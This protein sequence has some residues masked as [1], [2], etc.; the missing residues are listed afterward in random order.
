MTTTI[1]RPTGMGN[2][3]SLLSS[4]S[5][6]S[7]WANID[8]S[9]ANDSDEAHWSSGS[10]TYDEYTFGNPTRIGSETIEKIVITARIKASVVSAAPYQDFNLYIYDGTGTKKYLGAQQAGTVYVNQEWELTTNWDDDA[11]TWDDLDG[12]YVGVGLSHN[13]AGSTYISQLFVTVTYGGE[14]AY[15]DT[16]G[17]GINT[18]VGLG[19]DES[20]VKGNVRELSTE[21][22]PYVVPTVRAMTYGRSLEAPVGLTAT[23]EREVNLALWLVIASAD[24]GT[25][26]TRDG[27]SWSTAALTASVDPLAG[28]WLAQYDNRLVLLE[29]ANSGF[30]YS[31]KNDLISNWTSKPKFPNEPIEFTG[32]FVGRDGAS[33][34]QLQFITPK[35]VGYLDVYTNF[36]HGFTEA[37]WEYDVSAGKKGMYFRGYTYVLTGS[38]IYQISDGNADPIGPDQDDGMPNDLTGAIVDMIGVGMWIVIAINGGASGKSAILKRHVN[39]K[40]WH[41]VYKTAAVNTEITTLFWD[42]G[43]LYFGEGTD[44]KNL[45]L[46]AKTANVTQITEYAGVT[47]SSIVYPWFHTPYPSTPA[48]AHKVHAASL[49]M[50]ASEYCDIYYRIDEETDW[51]LLGRFSSSPK[52]TPLEF[53]DALYSEP[54]GL[55]FNRIQLKEVWTSAGTPG[56]YPKI[57]SLTLDYRTTPEVLLSWTQIVSAVATG[58]RSGAEIIADMMTAVQTNPLIPYYPSGS[59]SG[60][61]YYVQVVGFPSVQA[62]TEFGQ[63][64]EYELKLAQVTSEE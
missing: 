59:K 63:E 17:T 52:P 39:G 51:T 49:D 45:A 7:R 24:G 29:K 15:N 6:S 50:S 26:K 58:S 25:I 35:G 34:P 3:T 11:W 12:L 43:I 48:T 21:I 56:T 36:V 32:L 10:M 60:T 55:A 5:V 14:F 47:T 53:D 40:H 61:K 18:E 37:T 30:A 38:G 20:H 54:R 46:S 28:A 22:E 42:S 4:P 8:E 27:S 9:V 44:V 23:F 2:V 13:N 41:T 57:E 1:V 64:G 31:E 19:G 16:Y 33:N 62:G